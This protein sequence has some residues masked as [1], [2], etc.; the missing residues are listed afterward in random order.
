MAATSVHGH[1]IPQRKCKPRVCESENLLHPPTERRR[2]PNENNQFLNALPSG[3][4]G[5]LGLFT[6]RGSSYMST[7]GSVFTALNQNLV[8]KANGVHS[9]KW[10]L[11]S[12]L[13]KN[14]KNSWW[15]AQLSPGAK[16]TQED[17]D[18]LRD[19]I[20]SVG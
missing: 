14:D 8:L 17:A 7:A 6:A 11:K 19:F 9:Q 16:L 4:L 2:N 15:T 12:N 20:P 13:A 1:S 10:T 3:Q 18:Y 5:A